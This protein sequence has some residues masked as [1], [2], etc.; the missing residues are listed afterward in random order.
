[1][2]CSNLR[3]KFTYQEKFDLSTYILSLFLVETDCNGQTNYRDCF[4]RHT[5]SILQFIN[6]IFENPKSIINN[7]KR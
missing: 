4:H 3:I 7:N 6:F 5:I 2:S 1:M